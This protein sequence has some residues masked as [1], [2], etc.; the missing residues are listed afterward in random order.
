LIYGV[1]GISTFAGFEFVLP[2]WPGLENILP[3]LKTILPNADFAS[4][5]T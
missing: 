5:A 4:K 2:S 1:R 3:E